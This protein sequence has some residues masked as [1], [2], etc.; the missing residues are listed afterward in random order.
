MNT[1]WHKKNRKFW[2]PPKK[3][4]KSKK[5]IIGRNW[6]ITT[7]LLRDS[8]PNYQCLK[9]TSCR[10]RP[11]PRMHSFTANKHFKSS[12]SFLSP[13]VC[14]MLC[15][16]PLCRILWMN[17]TKIGKNQAWPSTKISLKLKLSPPAL[18]W[19]KVCYDVDKH[20]SL[21]SLHG[22]RLAIGYFRGGK[23]GEG[24]RAIQSFLLSLGFTVLL[25]F[26]LSLRAV[27]F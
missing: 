26:W 24:L 19:L 1:G 14:S 2:N 11:P 16:M 23:R 9:I 8:N 10:W 12:R 6:T 3:L 27:V 25:C 15:R 21:P 13:C 17:S 4:K 18:G 7:C 20:L 5:K 22:Y